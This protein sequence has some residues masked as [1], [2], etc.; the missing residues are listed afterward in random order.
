MPPRA[1]CAPLWHKRIHAAMKNVHLVLLIGNYAQKYYLNEKCRATLTETVKNYKSFLPE[2]FP[3]VHPSPRNRIW[4]KKNP[5]FEKSLLP[6][7]QLHVKKS[8]S[9]T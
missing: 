3:L 6:A 5:W 7:L 1:E 8:L 9:R 4:Q 2:Y